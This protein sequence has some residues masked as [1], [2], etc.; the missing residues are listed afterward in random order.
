MREILFKAKRQNWEEL[1]K[2]KWWVIG[3][4]VKAQHG[5]Y[6]DLG[7]EEYEEFTIVTKLSCGGI[8]FVAIDEDTICQ[9]T[10][11]TDKNGN[12]IWEN[13]IV[14]GDFGWHKGIY[15][16]KWSDSESKFTF[17]TIATIKENQYE[18]IGNVFDNAEVLK[19]E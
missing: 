3:Y 8:E 1:P 14:S 19:T 17:P 11:L 12:K 9:Y 18:V 7:Y 10:G 2:D 13:D 16:I 5:R 15:I 6:T 4:L